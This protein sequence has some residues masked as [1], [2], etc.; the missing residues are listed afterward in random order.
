[1][2]RKPG[3]RTEHDEHA[4][5]RERLRQDLE[6]RGVDPL[7]A[8]AV[9]AEVEKDG[10][11]AE[12]HAAI[13]E[14]VELAYRVHCGGREDLAQVVRE[15]DEVARL[16]EDFGGELTK[17]DESLKTLSAFL[18]RMQTCVKAKLPGR[19]H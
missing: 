8:A 9:L 11:G 15:L 3:G 2:A 14:G 13:L 5:A 7:F 12:S 6:A 16:M 18:L 17:L 19:L 10:A 4:G 1:M